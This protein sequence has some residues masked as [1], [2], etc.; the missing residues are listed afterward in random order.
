MKQWLADVRLWIGVLF[1][2]RLYHLDLPP[3]DIHS[4]RQGL[5]LGT[6]KCFLEVDWNIFAPRTILSD[7]RPGYEVM[8]FPLLNYCIFLLWKVFGEAHWVFRLLGIS[9]ASA[10]LWHFY[11]IARRFLQENG[12]L[13]ATV[14]F[15]T[16]ICFM[17]AR[18]AMPDV[19]SLSLVLASVS[20]GW[21]YLEKGGRWRLP[22]FSVLAGAGLLSKIPAA[23]AM[24]LLL[25]P[26]FDRRIAINRKIWLTVFGAVAVAA[27]SAWY[28]VWIPWA[29]K[30]HQHTWF[31]RLPL[32]QAWFELWIKASRYTED[33]FVPDALQSRGA[34]VFV[35]LGIFFIFYRKNVRLFGV[36]L[37]Y[38]A[39]FLV[40]M[41]QVGIVFC[42]HEYYVIPYTPMMGLLAGWG[43]QQTVKHQGLFLLILFLLAAEA[44]WWKREDFFP[45]APE[46]PYGRLREIVDKVV[47][48]GSKVLTV[49]KSEPDPAMH[50]M[51]GR[52]GWSERKRAL[53]T[54]WLNGEATVGLDY[55]IVYRAYTADSLRYP[56]VYE[57]PDFRVYK[58][59]KTR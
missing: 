17:Y 41:L 7:S 57:D 6:A 56:T 30:A 50:Y 10:G 58:I 5:T 43:L 51:T 23:S 36:W 18:K 11:K 31:F 9:V 16:S 26:Y 37:A 1:L 28:F 4:Y 35:V 52:R 55:A 3:T 34:Y 29:E 33:R 49:G 20:I 48:P 12:A 27:M 32:R 59:K 47:P 54:T 24:V 8:E 19:F 2:V 15:G 22:V 39:I 25:A 21:D 53:D 46:A 44:I 42:S 14:L 13:A 38:S 45:G 40:F